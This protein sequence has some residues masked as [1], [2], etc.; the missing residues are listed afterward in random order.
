MPKPSPLEET[1]KLY[2][3][4][5]TMAQET[6]RKAFAEAEQNYRRAMRHARQE[7]LAKLNTALKVALA[8]E[9]LEEANRIDGLRKL[10]EAELKVLDMQET[11]APLSLETNN[12][13]LQPGKEVWIR[14]RTGEI[15]MAGATDKVLK[16]AIDKD[17]GLMIAA[18]AQAQPVK[19]AVVAK[20]TAGP[21]VIVNVYVPL[22]PPGSP[23]IKVEVKGI[24]LFSGPIEFTE[25][26]E[27]TKL[28]KRQAGAFLEAKV[29]QPVKGL[30]VKVEDQGKTLKITAKKDLKAGRYEI[31]ITQVG[32]ITQSIT[33]SN[34]LVVIVKK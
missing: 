12:V 28:L 14:T 18:A 16:V 2:D 1:Q 9:K 15:S 4:A 19:Y 33:I 7:Y 29:L 17:K 22:P 25:G 6:K 23:V 31:L 10:M 11:S 34:R 24:E 32:F 20:G 27:G 26:K 5:Q 21:N 30:T 13:W 3:Q 8:A